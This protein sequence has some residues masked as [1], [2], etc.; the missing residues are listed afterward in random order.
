M[1]SH[2][3]EIHYQWTHDKLGVEDSEMSL[4]ITTMWTN[5]VKVGHPTPDPE[6]LGVTWEPV[7][8]D[9]IRQWQMMAMKH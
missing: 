8:K 4:A 2:G 6:D 9:D 5:F 7:T 3:D 1:V